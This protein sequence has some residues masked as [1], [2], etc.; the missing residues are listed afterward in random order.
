MSRKKKKSRRVSKVA[1]IF[2]PEEKKKELKKIE[3]MIKS[4]EGDLKELKISIK[5]RQK[6][7]EELRAIVKIPIFLF[8][9]ARIRRR[10]PTI[11]SISG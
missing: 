7:L 6:L 10:T 2:N 1:R 8:K 11:G 4:G 9:R 5:S 3:K